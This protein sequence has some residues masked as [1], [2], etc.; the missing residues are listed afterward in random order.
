M[1]EVQ[2]GNEFNFVRN[3]TLRKGQQNCS[4]DHAKGVGLMYLAALGFALCREAEARFGLG[5]PA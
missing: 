4:S 5:F 3:L 2:R 1:N